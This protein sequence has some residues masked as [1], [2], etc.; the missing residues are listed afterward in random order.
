[1]NYSGLDS[2]EA[3]LKPGYGCSVQQFVGSMPS[4]VLNGVDYND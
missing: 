3:R 1:V 4:G 2:A